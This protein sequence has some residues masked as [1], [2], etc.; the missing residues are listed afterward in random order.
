MLDN[1]TPERAYTNAFGPSQLPEINSPEPHKQAG[2]KRR[3]SDEGEKSR[4]KNILRLKTKQPESGQKLE[5]KRKRKE[6]RNKASAKPQSEISKFWLVNF[7]LI[8]LN[9]QKSDS[10]TNKNI[11][12]QIGQFEESKKKPMTCNCKKSKCLKFY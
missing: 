10:S 12:K 4:N 3:H 8:A 1:S 7:V 11:G 5:S 6:R 2:I 9:K